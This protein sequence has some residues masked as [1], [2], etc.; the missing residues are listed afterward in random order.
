MTDDIQFRKNILIRGILVCDTGMHIG[1]MKE[2]MAI[3]GTDSPVILDPR[4]NLPIIPGSSIKGKMRSLIELQ[5]EYALDDSGNLHFCDDLDCD[6]CIVFGRGATEAV[7]SGPTRLIVRDAHP[8]KDTQDWWDRSEDMVHGTEIKGENWINRITSAATPRFIERVPAGSEFKFEMIYSAYQTNDFPERLKLVFKGMHLLED[9]Y[10]GASGSR[11]Y[12]KVRFK[13]IELKQKTK[14]D[15]I[16]GDDWA[17][18]NGTDG[19]GTAQGLLKWLN[20]LNN[21]AG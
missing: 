7:K 2:S 6:L 20:G 4:T 10:I 3:G 1:G 16:S 21:N 19:I 11:G 15:Y 5:G 17:T 8:T 13:D 12:G 9:S 18:V 14:S